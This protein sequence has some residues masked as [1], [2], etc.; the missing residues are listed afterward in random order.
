MTIQRQENHISNSGLKKEKMKDTQPLLFHINFEILL[1][2][3]KKDL[4]LSRESPSFNLELCF[5]E[6]PLLSVLLESCLRPLQCPS[7]STIPHGLNEADV[8]DYMAL[9]K[10]GDPVLILK[11]KKSVFLDQAHSVFL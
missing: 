1:E 10:L 5:L 9:V 3:I 11:L 6:P 7:L 4:T 2:N 8:G